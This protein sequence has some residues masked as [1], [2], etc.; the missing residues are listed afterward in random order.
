MSRL[1]TNIDFLIVTAPKIERDALKN[2][3]KVL[4]VQKLYLF[5][6]KCSINK[7]KSMTPLQSPSRN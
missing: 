3:L 1:N 6:I 5:I 4:L 2:I 7:Q